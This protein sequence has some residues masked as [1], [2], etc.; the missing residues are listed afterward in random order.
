M[1][2]LTIQMSAKEYPVKMD[3]PRQYMDDFPKTMA[4][5]LCI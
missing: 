1:S 4:W 2:I 5:K 3:R